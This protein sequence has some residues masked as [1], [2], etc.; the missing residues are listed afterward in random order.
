MVLSLYS[1]RLISQSCPRL[2]LLR[3]ISLN[4]ELLIHLSLLI[5]H[6]QVHMRICVREGIQ[7]CTHIHICVC[8]HR[9]SAKSNWLEVS[10]KL[11]SQSTELPFQRMPPSCQSHIRLCVFVGEW[12]SIVMSVWVYI[13]VRD[14]ARHDETDIDM[15]TRAKESC[16]KYLISA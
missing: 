13:K 16:E 11:I 3:L 1:R 10:P 9:C 12:Q 2:V 7:G 8:A 15:L 6:T 14:E 4:T 5:I